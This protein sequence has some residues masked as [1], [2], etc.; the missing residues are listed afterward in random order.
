MG[1]RI[2]YL[3]YCFISLFIDSCI[4]LFGVAP[5]LHEEGLFEVEDEMD[6][7][8]DYGLCDLSFFE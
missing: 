7:F 6:G 3:F 1:S 8:V 2:I 5:Q 4:E